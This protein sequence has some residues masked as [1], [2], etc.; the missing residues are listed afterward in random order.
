[1]L[2][3]FLNLNLEKDEHLN[4]MNHYLVKDLS[5]KRKL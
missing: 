2:S 1:M 5:I 3:D 4:E